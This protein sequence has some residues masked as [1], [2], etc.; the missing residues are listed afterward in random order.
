MELIIKGYV[1]AMISSVLE[2]LQL[3]IENQ[4]FHLITEPI[5]DDH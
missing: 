2:V 3:S 5:I 4:V 1:Y